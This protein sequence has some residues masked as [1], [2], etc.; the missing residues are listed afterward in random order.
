MV[1][2]V[3][4]KS[5]TELLKLLERQILKL[6]SLLNTFLYCMGNGFMR[7]TKWDIPRDQIGGRRHGI[8]EAS[9]AG[10]FHAF[11][12]EFHLAHKTGSNFHAAADCGC[13]VEERLLR[14]LHIFVVG[15]WKAFYCSQERHLVADNPRRLP[16][17]QLERIR[18]LLLRHGAAAGGVSF[19]QT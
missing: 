1:I 8:H 14:L 3:R 11:T 16:A 2:N 10:S 19:R 5:R 18:I 15:K 7:L 12:V 6:A 9:L 4:A 13:R 17:N